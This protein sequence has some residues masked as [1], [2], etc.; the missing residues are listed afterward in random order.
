MKEKLQR[1]TGID[2]FNEFLML[3]LGTFLVAAGVYFFKFP[4]NFSTGG[5]SG[6]SIVLA[7]YFPAITP[8]TFVSILNYFLLAV[9]FIIFGTG[10]GFKTAYATVVMSVSIQVLEK[11]MPMDAPF[12]S[13][14]FMELLFAVGLP[15]V[16]S[17]VLF[18][19]DASSGGTDVVAMILKKYTSLDIGKAL[20][21]SDS[22][23]TLSACFAFGM[24]TGLFSIFGLLIKAFLVDSVIESFNMCKYFT[25]VSRNPDL[26][27]DYITNDLKRSATVVPG[28]GAFTKEDQTVILAVMSRAQAVMLRKYIRH[29]DPT[30]F[31]MITNTSEIIGKGFRGVA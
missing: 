10:F 20:L 15:A 7:R 8:G 16:G 29:N 31:M 6:L 19:I 13:Q 23:I 27:C 1:F 18:N 21:T 22:L 12:T 5:V 11:V 28:T 14:P 17:A 30:A 4:N 25:I 24:E 2:S 9:G 26:I 3:N